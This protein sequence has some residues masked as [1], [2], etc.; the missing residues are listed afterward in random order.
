MTTRNLDYANEQFE[1]SDRRTRQQP[2]ARW[3]PRRRPEYCKK[4]SP[5]RSSIKNRNNYRSVG[6]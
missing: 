3:K 1:H 2:V 4:R 5:V 6:F